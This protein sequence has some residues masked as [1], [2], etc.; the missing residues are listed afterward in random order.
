MGPVLITMYNEQTDYVLVYHGW[1]GWFN[2]EKG[3]MWKRG[4][5]RGI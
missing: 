4:R 2:R 5:G 3:G 1:T